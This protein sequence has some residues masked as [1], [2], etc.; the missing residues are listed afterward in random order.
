MNRTPW[1]IGAA[2][3]AAVFTTPAAAD[4]MAPNAGALMKRAQ[5]VFAPL[6]KEVANPENP[7]TDSKVTLGR[8]LYYDPRL[9]KNRDV[10]CN[11][12][13]ALDKF[14][15]DGEATSPGHRGQRGERNSP[16]VYNAALHVAQFWD[17]RAADVE[18][19]AKGPV[20]NPIEMAMASEEQ[21]V[22][23]LKSIPG[24]GRLF[25]QAFPDAKDPITYDNMARAIG[26]FERR[27]LTPSRF[28]AFLGGDASALET[29]E[30]EGLEAFL[31]VGCTACHSGVGIGGGSYQKLGLIKPFATKDV[32]R[33]TVTGNDLERFFFKVPS[34]RN[35]AE[36]GPYFHDGS[37]GSLDE[38]VRLMGRHQLG[39]ELSDAQVGKLIAFLGSLTGVVDV[40]YTAK[41]VLP[42]SGPS[43][44]AADPS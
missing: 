36:T 3:C 28:D 38:A 32:G 12:C 33:A 10:S 9:S 1:I 23:V 14:G 22:A 25:S 20:L 40:E 24:Y 41:P 35:I 19:Q 2:L 44:P 34:L 15:V 43:T 42:A 7:I 29:A 31:G 6:P 30:L 4:E 13:H 8:N 16:T 11:S 26:A 5:G 21:V 27:L 39:V 18:A 37:V 17:G